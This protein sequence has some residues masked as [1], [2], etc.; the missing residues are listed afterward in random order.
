VSAES[1]ANGAS[2]ARLR[3][4]RL[5]RTGVDPLRILVIGNAATIEPGG[6]TAIGSLPRD[7][8]DRLQHLTA[9]GVDLDVLTDLRSVLGA[10]H[11]TFA[12]WR[13]WRYDAVVV[14]V[15]SDAGVWSR[16]TSLR[17]LRRFFD[18]IAADVAAAVPVFVASVRTRIDGTPTRERDGRPR[19]L[20]GASVVWLNLHAVSGRPRQRSASWA[21]DIVAALVAGD[22]GTYDG[23]GG[24]RALR[25]APDD[26][27][28]RQEALD[29][30]AIVD[31]PEDPRLD[32]VVRATRAQFG[33]EVAELNFIDGARN[34]TMAAAGL[35][36]SEHPREDSLCRFTIMRATPTIVPDTHRDPR[37]RHNRAFFEP[38]AVRFYAAHPI[39]SATGYRIG[40]L[41]IYD[42]HPRRPGD[43]DLA[44]LRDFALLAEAEIILRD[45]TYR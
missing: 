23:A 35:D 44:S 33:T 38:G 37:L 32:Y 42:S 43:V 17:Q 20:A 8:A 40:A 18:A 12:R 21:D 28:E 36:R 15:E 9:R 22:V 24:A 7:L 34:W 10:M 26:E 11:G 39:E 19:W 2:S 27:I 45:S 14:V 5:H 13:L 3:V 29:E 1:L 41:C 4:Q 30:L 25:D 31:S 6:S 16:T